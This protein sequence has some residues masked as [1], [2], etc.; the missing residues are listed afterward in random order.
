VIF[1]FFLE[2]TTADNPT[3]LI[4]FLSASTTDFAEDNKLDAKFAPYLEYI[5]K[6]KVTTAKGVDPV[7]GNYTELY[8]FGARSW[9]I[10][11]VNKHAN[12]SFTFD[13]GVDLNRMMAK[14]ALPVYNANDGKS[15]KFDSR[16]DDKGAEP[17][18]VAIGV[19][20]G[21]NKTLAF[22]GLERPGL[23]AVYDVSD[24]TAPVFHSMNTDIECEGLGKSPQ[25]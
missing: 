6:L 2:L 12:P 25:C 8:S 14:Y 9:S 23:I 21:N 24:P 20:D 5:D 3:P 10:L 18:S 1:F 16:S 13:S 15:S 4:R 22:I 17:E 19:A 11:K 7:T